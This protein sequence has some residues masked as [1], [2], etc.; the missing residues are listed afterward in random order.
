MASGCEPKKAD[1][2]D[3]TTKEPAGPSITPFTTDPQDMV[4]PE[5]DK[6]KRMQDLANI[7]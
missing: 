5:E 2:D 6:I 7:K 1:K 4:K 3:K